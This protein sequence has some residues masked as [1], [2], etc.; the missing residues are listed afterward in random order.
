MPV[1]GVEAKPDRRDRCDNHP[2]WHH[3]HRGHDRHHSELIFSF[4]FSPAPV[5]HT[6][7]RRS[8]VV[9]R[10]WWQMCNWLC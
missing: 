9:N 3:K 8:V 5:V 4:N 10:T 1:P 6:P 2:R 7:V